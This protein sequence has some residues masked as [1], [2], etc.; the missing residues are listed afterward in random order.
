MRTETNFVMTN[1]C[2][3]QIYDKNLGDFVPTSECWTDC[4]QDQVDNF[5]EIVGHLFTEN[6]QAFR[7]TGFP[8]WDGTVDGSFF[9][10]NAEELIRAITPSRT[11]WYLDIIIYQGHLT[12]KLAH[13]DASG[14]ITVTPINEE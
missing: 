11:E 10:R 3:C 12:G 5:A 7:I 2:N 14:T 1:V 6:N 13:H 9:A 8:V 4:W